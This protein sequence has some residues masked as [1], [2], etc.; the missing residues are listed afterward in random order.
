MVIGLNDISQIDNHLVDSF[1]EKGFDNNKLIEHI[2]EVPLPFA[3]LQA[4]EWYFD[5][6]RIGY[7]EWKCKEPVVIKWAF[8]MKADIITLYFNQ[9]WRREGAPAVKDLYESKGQSTTQ[10][11]Q[12]FHIGSQRTL[13]KI[14]LFAGAVVQTIHK[15]KIR[16]DISNQ[17]GGSYKST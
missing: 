8:D 3:E 7:S 14:L 16:E 10:I 12:Y 4:K 6:I 15:G 17:W 5:G 2:Q 11:M 1:F 13:Y 9:Y